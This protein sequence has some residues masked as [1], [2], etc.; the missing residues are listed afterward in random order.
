MEIN[1]SISMDILAVI[2]I[3]SVPIVFKVKLFDGRKLPEKQ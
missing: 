2:R 1:V 3:L